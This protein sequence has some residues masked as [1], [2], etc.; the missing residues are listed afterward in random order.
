MRT[1][2]FMQTPQWN[3]DDGLTAS[4]VAPGKFQ[5]GLVPVQLFQARLDIG[6]SDAESQARSRCRTRAIIADAEPNSAVVALRSDLQPACGGIDAD[7]VLDGILDQWLKR[8]ARYI[9]SEKVRWH[10]HVNFQPIMKACLF[11]LQ[12]LADELELAL[13]GD[14]VLPPFE[15]HAQQVAKADQQMARSI[16]VFLHQDSNGVK[17]VEQKV[18]M[19][20]ALKVLKFGMGELHLQLRRS[21]LPLHSG[22]V[23]VD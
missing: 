21:G 14:L 10:V 20:L 16:D 5:R 4:T 3:G 9:D 12:I 18:R 19:Q 2:V 8:Q 17:T 13:E 1:R 6:E 15:G 11:D 22:L 23:K 7:A